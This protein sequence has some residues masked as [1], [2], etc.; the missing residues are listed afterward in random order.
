MDFKYLG[1][2]LDESGIDEEKCSRKMANGRRVAGLLGLWL[3]LEVCSLHESLLMPVLRYGS[4]K[5][6]WREEKSR[7]WAVQMDNIRGL[8][9]IREWIKSRIHGYGR[10]VK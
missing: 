3:M 7:I 4:E 8:L 6:I 2:V 1:C 5:M 9:G 10:C